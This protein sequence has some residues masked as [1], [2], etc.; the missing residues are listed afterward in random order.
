MSFQVSPGRGYQRAL[1]GK[2]N[3]DK[4]FVYLSLPMSFH[5]EPGLQIAD[6]RE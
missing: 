6:Q 2:P 1:W 4:G 3:R 5:D